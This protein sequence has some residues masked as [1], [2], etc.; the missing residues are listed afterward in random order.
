MFKW[1]G[2]MET[3]PVSADKRRAEWER[4]RRSDE[5]NKAG[6]EERAAHDLGRSVLAGKQASVA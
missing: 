5:K 6:G 3:E 1:L 2:D 4:K